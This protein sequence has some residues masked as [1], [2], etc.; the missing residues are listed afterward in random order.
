VDEGSGVV[1]QTEMLSAELHD[2]QRGEAPIEGDEKAYC[3]DKAYDSRALPE[4]LAE[5]GSEDKIAYKAKRN[6]ALANWQV[7]FTRRLRACA[8]AFSE[9]TPR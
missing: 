8:R 4:R 6:K 5:L 9:Q 7:R 1:R 2:S 3:A